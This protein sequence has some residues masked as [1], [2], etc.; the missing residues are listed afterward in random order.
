MS[1]PA[2]VDPF[3]ARHGRALDRMER[4]DP[5]GATQQIHWMS[6]GMPQV[7]EW[8]ADQ[9]IRFGFMANVIA[10]RC[11]QVVANTIA[12]LPF[13]A[14]SDPDKPM[15]FNH[16]ARLARLLGPTPGGPAPK[17]PARKLWA[18]SIAQ[19]L[20]TGRFAWELELTQRTK[21]DVVNIWPLPVASLKAIESTGGTSWFSSFR[22]GRNDDPKS[23][24]SDQVFY[25][26]DPAAD[27]FRQALSPLQASR[28]DLSLAVMGDRYSV[29]FLKNGAVPATI[30]TTTP[31]PDKETRGRFRRNWQANYAGPDRAG[32]THFN[33]VEPVTD[34]SGASG[35]VGDAI[36]VKVLGLPQKDQ[37]FVDQ[38]QAALTRVAIG[39]GVPWSKLDASGRTFDNAEAEDFAF[40]EGTILPL[41][42]ELQDEVNMD[43]APRLGSEVGWFDLSKVRCLSPNKLQRGD[44]LG[45][46]DRKAMFIDEARNF[47]GIEPLPNGQGAV[48]AEPPL[49][50]TAVNVAVPREAP[51]VMPPAPVP[52]PR[53]EPV[54][55][56]VHRTPPMSD[57][58][59]AIRRRNTWALTNRTTLTLEE[60]WRRAM[61]KLF[62]RQATAT[63]SRLTGKRGRQS[64]RD[65]ADA[66]AV[67]DRQ[68]WITETE[69]V[70]R[71]LYETVAG[72]AASLLSGRLGV[73][74]DIDQPDAQAFVTARAN[75]LAGQVT[76]TTYRQIQQAMLD[77]M[78]AGETIPQIGE[79]IQVVFDRASSQR[80]ETIART[81]VIS[82]YNGATT[83]FGAVAGPDVVAAQEWVATLDERTRVDH[84]DADGQTVGVGDAFAIGGEALL[85]P[86]DP[87]GSPEEVVNCRCTVVLLT[88]DEVGDQGDTGRT[89]PVSAARAVL[90]LASAGANEQQIRT[91]LRRAA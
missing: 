67:F 56:R 11:V 2:L 8:D 29:A 7:P 81:E 76:D 21:G 69:D 39:L 65:G 14:G 85:Y 17:L 33:E 74:F 58:Q 91:A 48:F 43:L 51:A 30:V 64:T 72:R 41:I 9:A 1:D 37:Q 18:W 54:P 86:G 22:Y 52:V 20:V 89:V 3:G 23:L 60:Q 83:M 55:I 68:H 80:A 35:K 25:S 42:G 66:D 90:A 63:I 79:R 50:S 32:G 44:I 38:H 15:A 12:S 53:T 49:P 70:A 84:A 46:L 71:D 82:S 47:F 62:A 19:R 73:S 78:Q 24:T 59:R 27:D 31:F 28:Y 40:W 5:I 4:R 26:W 61:R 36:D 45:L 87:S 88:P 77:G 10:Y 6:P 57:E 75:Q 16:N 13:R 34:G